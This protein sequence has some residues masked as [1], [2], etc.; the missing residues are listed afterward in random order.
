MKRSFMPYAAS[1]TSGSKQKFLAWRDTRMARTH[2]TIRT[3]SAHV[4][5]RFSS[6][7]GFP[8]TLE[9]TAFPISHI[10]V[11]AKRA[12]GILTK[13]RIRAGA[14]DFVPVSRSY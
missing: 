14:G 3:F 9:K 12:E 1:V 4:P 8:T 7:A 5:L 10:R 11:P 13:V 2:P 6:Q